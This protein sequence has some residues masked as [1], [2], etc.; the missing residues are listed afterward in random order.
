MNFNAIL[1]ITAKTEGLQDVSNLS[2]GIEKLSSNTEKY[3]KT[4]KSVSGDS[5]FRQNVVARA[6]AIVGLGV[7]LFSASSA[8][9]SFES[10][11]A[12]VR[13]VVD[14]L[15]SRAALTKI[16][17]EI[18]E[19]SR[20]M[21][22]AAEGFAEIYAAAGRSGV[23]RDELKSF[24]SQVAQV[25]IAFD[26]TSQ[27]AGTAMGQIRSALGLSIPQLTRLMD[28]LNA[29]DDSSGASAAGL[30]EFMTRAGATGK[31]AGLSAEQTAT[32]GAA[33]MEAGFESEVAATSF[34]NLIKALSRGP[35]MTERQVDAL[36]RLGY[37]MVDAKSMESEL[38]RALEE[39]SKRR[40]D[41]VRDQ[42][43][44]V[45]RLAEEQSERRIEIARRETDSL[46]KE[47]NRRFRNELQ[48]LQDGWDDQGQAQEDA[49]RQRAESQIRMLKKEE[50]I[51]IQALREQARTTG[52]N[53][54]QQIE[55]VRERYDMRGETIRDALDRELKQQRRAARNQQQI[56]RDGIED[57][58]DLELGVNRQRFDAMEQ[59][60]KQNLDAQKAAAESRFDILKNVEDRLLESQKAT[61]KATG[62]QMATQSMQGF[63]DR[64]QSDAIGVIQE[65]FGKI[66]SLPKAKQLSVMSDLF[67]DEA[68]G[69]VPMINN[70]ERFKQILETANDEVGTAGSVSREY[71]IRSQTAANQLQ[72]FNN[73]VDSLKIALGDALLPVLTEVVNI[74][75]PFVTG[76]ANLTRGISGLITEIVRMTG[77]HVILGS[78]VGPLVALV[79]LVSSVW[80]LGA[81]A[82]WG[83][84]L[85]IL[86]FMPGPLRLITAG[87]LALGLAAS[88][89]GPI[90]NAI[91][92]GL[93][94][95]Q[96]IRFAAGI[97]TGVAGMQ[98][99]LLGLATWL[100]STFVPAILAFFSGPVGWTVLAVAA[101]VAMVIAFRKPIGDFLAWA[102]KG[103]TE[104]FGKIWNWL[105]EGF[106]N[107]MKKIGDFLYNIWTG[108]I[109]GIKSIFFSFIKMWVDRINF[110]IGGVNRLIGAFNQ[111]RGP[112]ISMVPPVPVP[113]FAQGGVV[114]RP[115]LAMVGE[116]GEREYI[117]PESKMAGA[118]AAYISGRRGDSILTGSAS[119]AP[120]TINVQT[121]PVMQQDGNRWVTLADLERAMRQTESATLARLRTPSARLALGIR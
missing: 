20:Q 116:G 16:S 2:E 40:V 97:I 96:A 120:A 64:M 46:D 42:A 41:A 98:T 43:N 68:R 50:D 24:A 119:A 6:A 57:R 87:M 88:P 18:I 30:V 44:E 45:I 107:N 93:T 31:I 48:A 14:G 79:T 95:F 65:V 77:L 33:M 32:F 15:Q 91:V 17:N 35:S 63:A 104:G 28:A 51:Q 7:G 73:A 13:K 74:L 75:T 90:I 78:L 71:G 94:A 52:A 80:S 4:S 53:L 89:L 47:I 12:D 25:S 38:T 58:R 49:S 103:F 82:K 70:L 22:I 86:A 11:L 121:G 3:E 101:V 54:D 10:S 109:K 1:R 76:L 9:V 100:G 99:A 117:I 110:V 34:N 115:T 112:Q 61:A 5:S 59:Q 111:L 108:I 39:E 84:G 83:A 106:Q 66:N 19:L 67:G 37:S 105:S 92:I 102:W 36:R 26:M 113:G 62:E 21:P 69:L 114:S 72:L 27:E 23:A 85:K 56:I 29:I 55:L 60:E 81:L 118:S 8:A